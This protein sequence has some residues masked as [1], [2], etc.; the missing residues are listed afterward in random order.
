MKRHLP[1]V[2]KQF[3]PKVIPEVITNALPTLLALPPT[4]TSFDSQASQALELTPVGASLVPHILA[5]IQPQL[6]KL[7][8]QALSS[9]FSRREEAALEFEEDFE[10]HKAELMQIRDDGID[11]LQREATDALH[12][13]KEQGT[14]WAE[15]LAEAVV[16]AVRTRIDSLRARALQ[17]AKLDRLATQKMW[18][19]VHEA[20]ERGRRHPSC[21]RRSWLRHEGKGGYRGF[22]DRWRKV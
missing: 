6:L 18:S 5:H 16:D 22:G 3:L 9:A 2:L 17:Q 13:A 1:A 14:D 7:H 11:D 12:S 19:E 15:E 8:T 10:F 20:K 4:F 21:V